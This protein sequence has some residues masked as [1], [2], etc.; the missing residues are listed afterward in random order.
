MTFDY[1]KLLLMQLGWPLGF[2]K[3]LFIFIKRVEN[4]LEWLHI[5]FCPTGIINQFK[6][7]ARGGHCS[8][9]PGATIHERYHRGYLRP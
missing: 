9:F 7:A 5:R 8:L 3:L 6:F 4:P 2:Q 1:N